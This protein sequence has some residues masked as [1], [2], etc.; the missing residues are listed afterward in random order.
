MNNNLQ[1]QT[2]FLNLLDYT[3]L[4]TEPLF[5]LSIDTYLN[6]LV[7]YT[8]FCSVLLNESGT[9]QIQLCSNILYLIYALGQHQSIFGCINTLSLERAVSKLCYHKKS[10]TRNKIIHSLVFLM[11]PQECSQKFVRKMLACK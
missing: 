5:W 4:R 3:S 9:I 6:N 1:E 7:M 11:R 2:R 8:Q 10:I